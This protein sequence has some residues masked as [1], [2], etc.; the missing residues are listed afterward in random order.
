MQSVPR[1]LLGLAAVAAL[2]C[3]STLEPAEV[4][5]D[6]FAGAPEWVTNDCSEFVDDDELCGVGSMNGSRNV[7]LARTTAIARARTEIA[8]TLGVRVNSL[9]M[10]ILR[11]RCSG[12][13]FFRRAT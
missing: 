9:P 2:G 5:P 8:R 10:D 13:A 4:H 3:A 6:E 7:A 12:A 11:S 1:L